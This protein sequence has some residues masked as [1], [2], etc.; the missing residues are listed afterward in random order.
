MRPQ[1]R[2]GRTASPWGGDFTPAL[3]LIFHQRAKLLEDLCGAG[4]TCQGRSPLG[5]FF[6]PG[7]QRRRGH[8]A[9]PA[10][11]KAV[12]D[13]DKHLTRLQSCK[14]LGRPGRKIVKVKLL[15]GPPL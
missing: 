3:E 13:E 1:Q 14:E 9:Q 2:C 7:C 6:G 8:R 15:H 5:G 11:D 10:D 12:L 4:L